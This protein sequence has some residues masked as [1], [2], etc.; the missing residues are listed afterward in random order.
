MIILHGM[1]CIQNMHVCFFYLAQ[2]FCLF[3]M[4]VGPSGYATDTFRI[5]PLRQVLG[6]KIAKASSTLRGDRGRYARLGVRKSA[7][8]KVAESRLNG[9]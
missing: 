3:G 9:T 6:E 5:Y 8:S 1:S 4:D 7:C 2:T